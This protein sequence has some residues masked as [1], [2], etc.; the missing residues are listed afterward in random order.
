MS[1][2]EISLQGS[3]L[4]KQVTDWLKNISFVISIKER[5]LDLSVS[6]NELIFILKTSMVYE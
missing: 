5:R 3:F 2:A 4:S 6:C 1:F